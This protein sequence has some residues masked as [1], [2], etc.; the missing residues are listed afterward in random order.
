MWELAEVAHS[1]LVFLIFDFHV[2]GGVLGAFALQSLQN[3]FVF[4]RDSS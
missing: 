2:V 1:F 4:E 3:A